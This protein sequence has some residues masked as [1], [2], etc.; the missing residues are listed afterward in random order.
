L[1]T[2][3]LLDF[4]GVTGSGFVQTWYDQS[5]NGYNATTTGGQ[6]RIVIS[7]VIP[8]FT[9][10][11][12]LN[13]G[14]STLLQT[15]DVSIPSPTTVFITVQKTQNNGDYYI[16]G[17]YGNNRL[18]LLN[19]GYQFFTSNN[20]STG[21]SIIVPPRVAVGD[22]SL[23]TLVKNSTNSA[24]YE[25]S[26]SLATGS[27]TT[28]NFIGITI[29]GRFTGGNS[30]DNYQELIIYSSDQ[31]TNQSAIE[32]NINTNYKI[33]GSVTASFDPDY[34]A[35][36]T[37]TGITQPTQSAALE[38]LVSDLKSYGLWSK[39]KAIYPMV[40]DK[41]NRLS[42]SQTLTNNWFA[43]SASVTPSASTAPDGTLTGFAINEG[44]GT[45][46]HYI[47]RN[48]IGS[49]ITGSE[50]VVS[51]YGKF[52][53]RPWMGIS[54]NGNDAWFNIQ[55]GTTGSY[56]GSNATVTPAP[57]GWYRCALFFT[58]SATVDPPNIEFH[59]ADANGNFNYTG[60]SSGSF[61]WG[62]QFENGNLLGPYRN[63]SVN[64]EGNGF[65]TGSMLD[66]MKFN[67]RNPADT[68]AAFR[69]EYTGNWNAGYNGNKPGPGGANVVYADTNLIPSGNLASTSVHFSWYAPVKMPDN[70]FVGV[71]DAFGSPNRL[72]YL[73]YLGDAAAILNSTEVPVTSSNSVKNGLVVGSRL[74]NS[75]KLYNNTAILASITSS[76]TGSATTSFY[77]GADHRFGITTTDSN[78][79]R[80]SF[81]SLGDGLTDYE[82]KA[83]Y[84][85][86]Q[87][88]QTSLGRQ[89]Y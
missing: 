43:V 42:D 81:G 7:G 33:F 29:G 25:N 26:I 89:V 24:I 18:A 56:T 54:V 28:D 62:V 9:K 76:I 80:L 12:T 3:G 61:L 65:T 45:G 78:Q 88:F 30:P 19:F 69:I 27:H 37:A 87:K 5:G 22:P 13:F 49:I 41:N 34:Q 11:P 63:T 51:F 70:T 79:T 1:D 15:A 84:W 20:L 21:F 8:Y 31:T 32:S 47:N 55:T 72:G 85:I 17:K 64:T 68:D 46:E 44:T 23:L 82:A 35:F 52:Q 57:N 75:L 6:P 39:M 71:T 83:L 10:K 60:A 50:Y 48:L 16:D 67:L 74:S 40:T 14:D 58:A 4:V 36:I 53:T 66:Q 38:T 2:V 77:W 59:L 73:N 86:V